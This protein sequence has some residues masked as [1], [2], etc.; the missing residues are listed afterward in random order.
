MSNADASTQAPADPPPGGVVS[1]RLELS[2]AE[3]AQLHALGGSSWL[4]SQLAAAAGS[5][6]AAREDAASAYLVG[7]AKAA[8]PLP[9][10]GPAVGLV[11]ALRKQRLL[12][13][14][15]T[16]DDAPGGD[17]DRAIVIGITALGRAEIER[18]AGGR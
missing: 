13:A 2:Q 10:S 7:L 1:V 15:V 5:P 3:A 4:R 6:G 8:F 9:V 17:G 14:A 12:E 18:L 11:D 16:Y